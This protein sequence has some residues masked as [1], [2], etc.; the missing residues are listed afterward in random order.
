MRRRS[1]KHLRS[2]LVVALVGAGLALVGPSATAA[3]V[4]IDLCA[5]P[6]SATLPGGGTVPIWGFGTPSAPG[7]CAT[8][9]ASLPGPV[10]SVNQGDTVTIHLGN[11]LPVGHTVEF[12]VPGIQFDPG[13]TSAASGASVDISFTASAPGTYIYQSGG[14]AG[15]QEAMGLSGALIVRPTTPNQAYGAADSAYDVEQVVVLGAIDP[16]FN[17]APETFDMLTYSAT[18]WTINGQSYP[19]TPDIVAAPGQRVLLRYVN[20]GFDN[21]TM[22][23]LGVHENV[24]AQDAH[25]VAVPYDADAETIPA[26]GTE[27]AIVTMPSY[28]APSANGFPLYNRQL[29]VTNGAQTGTSPTPG[30]G[31]GM[32][33]F[34]HS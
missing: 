6:G 20:A 11:A 4:A 17:A 30:T 19:D 3:P 10:L 13:A 32:L 31:G 22:A 18:Y 26:G 14:D 29:H 5:A 34:L 2:A 12:E 7:D 25:H 23:L 16:S 27:D 1:V 21:T 24:I 15:R 33:L 28:G 8:A 9:T